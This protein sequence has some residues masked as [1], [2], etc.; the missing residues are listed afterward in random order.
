MAKHLLDFNPLTGEQVVFD[1]QGDKVQI[2]HHQ[3]VARIIEG[4]KALAKNDGLTKRGIK[5]DMWHYATI[6]NVVALKWKQEKGVDINNPAHRKAMFK[7]LND[8]E[9][10][11]LKTTTLKHG[12]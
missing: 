7:L 9:Y 1:Y 12:G 11:Y 5:N 2:T 3:D 6:P 4:N 10:A 8:P